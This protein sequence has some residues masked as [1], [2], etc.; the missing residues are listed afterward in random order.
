MKREPLSPA[1]L[2]WG[3]ASRRSPGKGLAF[4]H[5]SVRPDPYRDPKRKEEERRP[6][7]AQTPGSCPLPPSGA[8]QRGRVGLSPPPLSLIH[9]SE[10]T[11][12]RRLSYAVFCLT[13]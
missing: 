1:G 11:R 7:S 8:K 6:E 3:S 2:G 9:I 4:F 10:P 13:K 12:L 5:R